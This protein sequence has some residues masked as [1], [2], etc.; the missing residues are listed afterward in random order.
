MEYKL[1]LCFEQKSV[2]TPTDKKHSDTKGKK[3]SNQAGASLQQVRLP[4]EEEGWRMDKMKEIPLGTVH[5]SL[6]SLLERSNRSSLQDTFAITLQ[7]KELE[8]VGM[9]EWPAEANEGV[10]F[11][12]SN[13]PEEKKEDKVLNCVVEVQ[14]QTTTSDQQ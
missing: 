1:F 14:L 2:Q 12:D 11:E 10:K 13:P 4:S 7:Q 6:S 5:I 3:K 9:F 8:D